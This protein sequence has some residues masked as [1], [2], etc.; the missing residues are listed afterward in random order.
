M[1]PNPRPLLAALA[2]LAWLQLPTPASGAAPALRAG[3]AV[4]DI[5]PTGFPVLVNAMFTERTATRTVDP[6]HARA[7]ALDDGHTRLVLVLVDTCMMP[8]E[9]IDRAKAQASAATGLSVDR[10]MVSATHT[11]SAPAAMGC[12]GSRVDPRYAAFLPGRIAAAIEQAIGR[13]RPAEIGWARTDDWDHTFNRRWIRRPDRLLDDP[14]GHPTVRAHMHPGHQSPDAIGPSGPVDPGLSV[15]AVRTPDGQPLAVLANYSQHYYGSELL[16]ADYYGKFADELGR[17]VGGTSAQRASLGLPPFVGIMS[18]GTSGDLMWMDYGAPRREIGYEAYAR[19]IAQRTRDTFALMQFRGDVRLGMV[20]RKLRLRYRVPDASRLAWARGMAAKLG[21]RLPATL[22]EVYALE[23]LHLHERQE[24]ELVLQALRIGEVG[25]ATLPNEVYALTGLKLKAQSPFPFSFNIELANGAEGYIPTPEQHVLGGYTTWPARTAGLEVAAEPRIL[26]SLLEMLEELSGSPRRPMDEVHGPYARA[27]LDARPFAYWR[28]GEADGTVAHDSTA[29]ERLARFT[30]GVALYLPGVG[31]GEGVS[32]E[33]RLVPSAFSGPARINRAPHFAG[34]WLHAPLFPRSS[35][36][37]SVEFWFWNGLTNTARGVTGYLFSRGPDRDSGVPGDHLGL[38]GSHDTVQAGRLFFFNGN[39]RQQVLSGTTRI[40][41]R[42]WHHV[43]LVREAAGVRVHLDGREQPEILGPAELTLPFGEGGVFFATRSDRFAGL[44]GKLDEIAV[45]DRALSPAEVAAHYRASGLPAPALPS[46]PP[47]STA[48]TPPTTSPP[49]SAAESLARIRVPEGYRVELAAAEP[50]TTDPVA[51]DWDA[52][53]RLWVVEMADYP[54]GLDGNGKPGGRVRVLEDTDGDGRH[55]RST[56]FA[57]GLEFPTGLLVWRDGVLVTAAPDLLF[58]RDS[59]GDGR[60]DVKEVLWT[61]FMQDNQQLR[62]NGLR[63]GLD[64]WVYCAS[65]GH[66]R[67]HGTGT[68]VRSPKSGKTVALGSRDFRFQ[69]DADVLDPQS[70]PTQFGRNRDDWGHWFGTQNSWPLWHYVLPDHYLRRNPFVAA[71]DPIRQVLGPMNPPVYAASRQEKRFHNFQEAGHFTSACGG[72]IYRDNL[73]FPASVPLNS[74][75]CEP[76]HNLV[77]HGLVQD[78]GVSFSGRRAPGEESREFFASEDRWCRPVMTRTGPEGALW[79]VDMYRYMI[80]HPQWLPPEGRAELLPHYRAGDD[81]GRLYRVVPADA[82]R[83]AVPRLDRL[84]VPELVQALDSPNGWQRDKVHQLLLWK[85]A[86]NAV[87]DLVRLASQASRPQARLHALCVLDGLGQLPPELLLRA[88]ADAHPGIRENAVRLAETRPGAGVLAAA[89]A[90]VSDPSPKVRLQLALSLGEWREARAGEALARLAARDAADPFMVAAVLGSAHVHGRALAET[91]AR[92]DEKVW[93]TYGPSL[94]ELFLG[95]ND[96][97]ALA[98]TWES[99]L[100]PAPPVDR[101]AAWQ[102][103]AFAR[104]LDTLDRR[105]TTLA[106]LAAPS[107]DRLA[108]LLANF[109]P[110]V[111]AS[112]SS[113]SSDPQLPA[114]ER[115]AAAGLLASDLAR[116][117]QAL[118]ALINWLRPQFPPEAQR[119][120]IATLQATA[121]PR[122]PALLLERWTELG[123]ASRDAVLDALLSRSAWT[124]ELMEHVGRGTVAA[125]AFDAT[126]RARLARHSD[127]TIRDAAQRAFATNGVPT[128]TRAAV[129]AAFRP[130]LGLAGDA[131][132]GQAIHAKACLVCHRRDGQGNEIG[133]DLRSVVEH[134]PEKLLV[135]ILDPSADVQPGYQAYHCT[136]ANGEELYGVIAAETGNSVVL[137]LVD[138]SSRTLL[139]QDLRELR[140]SGLSLMPEGLEAEWKPQDL[141]DLIAFLKRP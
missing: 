85:K 40:P 58:L 43:V 55:D 2:F 50:L 28:L 52:A 16:S 20:E 87:P 51:I 65:G 22:P 93:M 68:V 108:A 113:R 5:S 98:R 70:G 101:H 32:P 3:A 49:L 56:V 11:H 41:E 30:P 114:S 106:R 61:G 4:I 94:I 48:G 24:T 103:T 102:I 132:S 91:A 10:M 129:V 109:A 83:R 118:A 82:P 6:L 26:E 100:I 140:G 99:V 88:L 9:L 117:A 89:T 57:E 92:G 35:Q 7:L 136:L 60:A 8:R 53:G 17:L 104:S 90:L 39:R 97:D 105:N 34:G 37:Y 126:R 54:L 141:A 73:L 42:T 77:H 44:E 14:F 139:R 122:L 79:V 112:A 74:F 116:R 81:K 36:T 47:T 75:T 110:R 121:E 131:N 125:F 130:A 59:D 18:Q 31:S 128:P 23:A 63:W 13:L 19:E 67:G 69:P 120:A 25:I 66:H 111:F 86:T 78:D 62:V 138:G 119:Q 46:A 12:L 133:P 115:I 137:K 80:E 76:F 96:R 135:N 107:G 15:L 124:R 84:S 72:M 21:D 27:I 127:G 29:S 38:G 95:Q 71:P 45:Y 64:N 1:L 134:A 33:P 123:P